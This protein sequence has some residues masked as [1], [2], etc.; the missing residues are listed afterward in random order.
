MVKTAKRRGLI[1]VTGVVLGLLTIDGM[2]TPERQL[3]VGLAHTGLH[4][5]QRFV[6]PVLSFAG[7]RCRF[8]PTCSRYAE[9][10]VASQGWPSGSWLALR[11]LARCGPWTPAGT[12][13]PPPVHAH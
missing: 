5:Y 2:R 1:A 12:V 6:S 11:R 9:A 3:G 10:V 4:A 8:T 13:D 7:A